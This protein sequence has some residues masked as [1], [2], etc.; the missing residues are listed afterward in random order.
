MIEQ[1]RP[2]QVS[3][4]LVNAIVVDH[5]KEEQFLDMTNVSVS[6]FLERGGPEKVV[7]RFTILQVKVETQLL[8]VTVNDFSGLGVFASEAVCCVT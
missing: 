2:H 3:Y 5:F 6:Q 8:G 4:L 7:N 1:E